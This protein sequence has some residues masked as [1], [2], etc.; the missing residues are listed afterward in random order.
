MDEQKIKELKILAQRIR[1]YALHEFKS[2]G[3]GH[4]GGSMSIAELLA[5]LYGSNMKFNPRKPD[6]DGRDWLVL[7]KGHSGPGLY[8]ALAW[9]GFFPLEELKTLNQPKTRLP[10]HCDR[11]LTPGIDMTTGSLGQGISTALGIALGHR[12]QRKENYVYLI[13]GDGECN[14]GQIWEGVQFAAHWKIDNMITFVDAN[15]KQLDG[16]TKD[17]NDLTGL[18]DK[19][20]CFGWYS[21][22]VDGHDVEQIFLAIAKAKMEKGRPSVIVLNTVKGK[23][24]CFAESI[25]LNHHMVIS[26]E[27]ADEAIKKLEEAITA[28]E[29]QIRNE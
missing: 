2:I 7:S 21:Q 22:N 15:K 16:Y 17:I 27:M 18:A 6:W 12:M 10:S 19:F 28:C 4:I 5:V 24:C 3:F 11:N 14:E 25:F 29:C 23:D 26:P 1:I 13:L 9:A 20:A 8:A